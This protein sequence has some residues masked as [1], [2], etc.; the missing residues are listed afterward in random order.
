MDR[1]FRYCVSLD[2]LY[3]WKYLTVLRKTEKKNIF[4]KGNLAI[5]FSLTTN[6]AGIKIVKLEEFQMPPMFS[7]NIT[8]LL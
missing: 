1:H 5:N 3:S 2:C 7:S 8:W 4:G 6:T